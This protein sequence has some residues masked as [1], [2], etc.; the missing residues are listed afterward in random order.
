[1]LGKKNFQKV[2]K[3][4]IRQQVSRIG[5]QFLSH[6]EIGAQEAAYLILQKHLRQSIIDVV[7]IDK[8]LADQRT[9]LLKSFIVL[10]ELPSST[11]VESDNILKRFIRRPRKVIQYC[12]ADFVSW[13]DTSFEKCKK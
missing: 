7:F 2:A 9:V 5:N 12:Y 10:K 1:M 11:N 3:F 13:F 6:V 8:N 4:V